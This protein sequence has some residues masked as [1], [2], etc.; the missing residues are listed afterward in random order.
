MTCS[1]S[2]PSR[3]S[4]MA[5]RRPSRRR[6]AARSVS[7]GTLPDLERLASD[8]ATPSPCHDKHVEPRW[9]SKRGMSALRRRQTEN[10]PRH[11]PRRDD[12]GSE[13]ST[14]LPSDS[15]P[16]RPDGDHQR[17]R[18]AMCI[19][20]DRSSPG[21]SASGLHPGPTTRARSRHVLAP[22]KGSCA[23]RSG[24]DI[25]PHSCAASGVP[26]FRQQPQSSTDPTHRS[27]ER[28][29]RNR[30]ICHQLTRLGSD[31]APRV[32]R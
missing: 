14:S 31:G 7:F 30:S 11:A 18:P 13:H 1:R 5:D 23:G 26:V 22:R 3:L 9:P 27:L 6:Q 8:N 15:P 25:R 16:T 10:A 29:V 32:D 20:P 2:F 4:T 24:P 12:R 28:P 17:L 19:S 21:A